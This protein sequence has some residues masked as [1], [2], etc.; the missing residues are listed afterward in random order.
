MQLYFFGLLF[1][2]GAT[3]NHFGW[4]TLSPSHL[5]AGYDVGVVVLV[6]NYAFVGIATS[7]VV[8]YLDNMTKT[9]A[10][11]A[12]MFVVCRAPHGH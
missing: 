8:K 3:V 10:A 6:L 2:M 5:T 1:G 4:D 11:N 9:F 7:A 12:A